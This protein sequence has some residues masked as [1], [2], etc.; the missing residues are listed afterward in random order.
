MME[1]LGLRE[2]VWKSPDWK[3]ALL[4]LSAI[5]TL[6]GSE[7]VLED[8]H[9][10]YTILNYDFR[11][12]LMMLQLASVKP[13]PSTVTTIKNEFS[14]TGSSAEH[15]QRSDIRLMPS[16]V[17]IARGFYSSGVIESSSHF[18]DGKGVNWILTPKGSS[19]AERY[20]ILEG[21]ISFLE[22]VFNNEGD[23]IL[24][25]DSNSTVKA[26]TDLKSVNDLWLMADSMSCALCLSDVRN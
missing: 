4:N 5:A 24:S 20:R 18:L 15:S 14:I 2:I 9:R 1:G 19:M 26:K 6:E 3:D 17:A 22:M 7:P 21:D 12:T 8:I 16:P 10:T 23:Y 11:R 25:S 13:C